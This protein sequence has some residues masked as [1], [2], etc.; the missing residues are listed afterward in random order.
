[1]PFPRAS[2]ILLHLTCLPGPWGI[3]DLG[4]AAHD[5][6]EFLWKAGQQLWQVLP[7][8]PTGDGNSPYQSYSA[9]AGNPLLL[10]LE[11]LLQEGLLTPRDVAELPPFPTGRVDFDAVRCFKLPLLW[12]SFENFQENAPGQRQDELGAFARQHATWLDDYALFMALKEEH[13]GSAWNQWQRSIACRAPDALRG[14]KDKLTPRCRFHVYLQ[15]QFF[16]QWRGLREHCQA[17]GIQLVGD[18]PIFV[19]HDSADVWAHSDLFHLDESGSPTVLAGVPPDY[20]SET[21]QLWA[22]PLYRWEAMA[23]SGYAWW[24][25]R[26]QLIRELVD[27]IRLDHFRG[28][29]AYWEVPAGETT[30]IKGRWVKG[31]GEHLFEALRT[32]L[33]ELPVVAEDLGII[34]PEVVALRERLGFP[35]MRVLQF[36]LEDDSPT[37]EYQ[38]RSFPQHCVVYTGTHDNDTTVGWFQGISPRQRARILQGL[39]TDGAQ[40]QEDI[41]RLAL[42]SPAQMAVIPL[43]DALGLG[44]EGRMNRPG[45]PRGNWEWRVTAAR[46]TD[47]LAG[48]LRELTEYSGRS[49][50]LPP[51]A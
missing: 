47:E 22:N 45:T 5:F 20:F 30:A 44:S 27:I 13:A 21:G 51:P 7:L 25:H 46:L 33:G 49:P 28:F 9:F 38:P 2:G 10:S 16:R 14:W 3:G 34:T 41:I 6:I 1:M 32:A 17:R 26:F 12:K 11:P 40:I 24:I 23:A 18:I 37:P 8:G 29:E 4:S 48:W 19:A 43:Q 15:Y 36:I 42:R 39:G 31:P 50:A 35:G